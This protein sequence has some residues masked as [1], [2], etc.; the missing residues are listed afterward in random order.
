MTN[1]TYP[2][3]NIDVKSGKSSVASTTDVLPLHIPFFPILAEKGDVGKIFID[4]LSGHTKRYGTRTFDSTSAFYQHPTL[5]ALKAMGYQKVALMRLAPD[6]IKTA[7]FV[8]FATVMKAD[9]P[10]YELDALGNRITDPT[11]LKPVQKTNASGAP[12]TAPGYTIDWGYR[13]L[14]AGEAFDNIAVTTIGT[15]SNPTGWIYPILG[16]L[17]RSPGSALNRQ[18]FRFYVGSDVNTTTEET[19]ASAMYRFEPAVLSAGYSA[20]VTAVPD[21]FTQKYNDVSLKTTAVDPSTETE[22]A[23]AGM[24]VNGYTTSDGTDL[25]DYDVHTYSDSVEAIG[26]LV[27]A[28]SAELDPLT[29]PFSINL[30]SGQ[31]TSGH[32]YQHFAVTTASASVVN[33]NVILYLQGGADGVLSKESLEGLL[34]AYLTG[35][36]NLDFQDNFQYPF[37]HFYDTGYS[38]ATKYDLCQIFSLRSDVVVTFST[39]DVALA[40]NTQLQDQSTGAALI[41]R[42]RTTPESTTYGTGTIRADIYQQCG[43]LADVSASVAYVPLTYDRMV[44]RCLYMSG[45]VIR[46]TPKGR[47]YS[48]VTLFRKLNWTSATVTQKQMNWDTAL[49]TV[50]YAAPG[51]LFY[52]DLRSVFSDETDLLSDSV[53]VD[54]LCGIKRIIADCWTVYSGVNDPKGKNATKIERAIDTATANTYNGEITTSTDVYQTDLDKRNGASWTIATQV[55]GAMPDRIWNVVLNSTQLDTSTSTTTSS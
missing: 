9:I 43:L 2:H 15:S 1:Y 22:Y 38:L 41:A 55:E 50:T 27:I 21:I 45:Q 49:N 6:G 11:T 4:D 35:E 52:A 7:G 51:V 26:N 39:Q 5:F 29:D 32:Y 40:N 16:V 48:E 13:A 10:Q 3:I 54:Y 46:G 19:I 36:D 24:L 34:S 14:A 18:G 8:L 25:L 42:I 20:S 44:K 30:I 17:G 31:D 37:T 23:F 47:P 12:L 33:A 53:Y 28:A